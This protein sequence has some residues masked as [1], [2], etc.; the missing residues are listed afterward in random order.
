MCG[1]DGARGLRPALAS[2]YLTEGVDPGRTGW[3]KDEKVFTPE[4]VKDMR[5]L[6][7]VKLDSQPRQMHNLFPPLIAERVT[8][9]RG[10]REMAIVAGI[11]DDLFGIDVASGEVVWK[12][13]YDST[14][15]P[16]ARRCT[17]RSASAARR[18]CRRWSRSRLASTR[19]MRSHG[20]AGCTRSTRPTDRTSRRPKV[21][22]AQRQAVRAE[23]R[24]RRR[25]HGDGARL[26]RRAERALFLRPGD[27]QGEHVPAR[28]AAACGAAGARRCRRRAS[29]T[30]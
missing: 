15:A 5:L 6:W 2:D 10:P 18:R 22:A 26:R 27:A 14:Y 19:S 17:T 9:A 21:H 11:S 1:A 3:M 28:P 29:S 23:R 30:W 12:K 13:R 25:V 4:N 16:P 24:Q 7:K 8:T 20:T